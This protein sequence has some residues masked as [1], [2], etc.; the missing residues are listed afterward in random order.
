[1][2]ERKRRPR[3]TG[4]DIR[5]LESLDQYHRRDILCNTINLVI[6][7]EEDAIPIYE[8]LRK[9]LHTHLL[10][11]DVN[12]IIDPILS[13]KRRHKD[14]LSKLAIKLGCKRI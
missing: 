11:T 4:E 2:Q 14:V 7:D 5:L 8:D 12:E 3:I 10:Q 6:R 13:D 9:S 1:M